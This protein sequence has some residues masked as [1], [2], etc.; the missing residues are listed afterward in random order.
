MDDIF[1]TSIR[2][3]IKDCPNGMVLID[4]KTGRF[5]VIKKTELLAYLPEILRGKWLG[6]N[7]NNKELPQLIANHKV[8]SQIERDILD[9]NIDMLKERGVLTRETSNEKLR[10]IAIK[11][12]DWFDHN[13][14]A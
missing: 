3:K 10:E 7:I 4:C 12:M 14:N 11:A 6:M 8:N 9:D 13:H 2:A 1:T 5:Q